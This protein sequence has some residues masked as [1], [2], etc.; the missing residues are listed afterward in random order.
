MSH[1]DEQR[2]SEQSKHVPVK[3]Y[4]HI[5]I[6]YN[7]DGY[8]QFCSEHQK[9]HFLA[10]R[11][12]YGNQSAAARNLGVPRDSVRGSIRSIEA[13]AVKRGYSP[14]HN[15]NRIVPDTLELTG[16]SDM[17][18]NEHGK[19]IWYKYSKSQ[20]NAMKAVDIACGSAIERLPSYEPSEFVLPDADKDLIPW[21]NIGDAHIG[22]LAHDA[23]VGH[24]FDIKIAKR[25]LMAALAIMISRAPQTD[26]CVIQD[27]GD[28]SH[29][30][31]YA[32]ETAH[33]GH[34]LDFDTRFHKMISAYT[35]VMLFIVDRALNKF[36]HVDVI[37]NQG[38]HSRVNDHWMAIMLRHL[39]KND[40]RVHVLR[41]ESI[42]IPYRMGNTFV[43]CHHTDKC[44]P[45]ALAGVMANDFAQDWGESVYHYIDGGHVHHNQVTKE[46]TGAKFES[47]NQLAPSD[48]YAHDGGWRSRSLLT[49]VLRSK[50][51]GE[52]GRLTLTVEEVKD[53]IL[54]AEPGTSAAVRREVYSV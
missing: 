44:K 32:G 17:Q 5:D 3:K 39:Y 10:C 52:T 33:S 16:L 45:T 14:K 19:P 48:K 49:T 1:Y 29:Y 2:E 31:N 42:F 23:E 37:I 35:D 28:M 21:F 18:V 7:D 6:D 54:K 12:T 13:K 22:M 27:M 36:N 8:L 34:A 51:Y 47:F 50:T 53:R 41:N 25:E 9:E 20:L 30:E 43:L 11:V 26:R 15:L 38:N 46:V 40:K 4:T 24:N